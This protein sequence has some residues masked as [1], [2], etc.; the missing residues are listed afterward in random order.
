MPVAAAGGE[1]RGPG[2]DKEGSRV[3]N[4]MTMNLTY[5]AEC[6]II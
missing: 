5:T 1:L 6:K 2:H 4:L 3:W